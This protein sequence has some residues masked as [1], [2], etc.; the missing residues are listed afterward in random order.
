MSQSPPSVASA[1]G[2]AVAASGAG[3]A[4][5]LELT[6]PRI[7]LLVT[8][9]AAAGFALASSTPF[10]WPRFAA[11]LL[12][13]ALVA[14]GSA[15]FNMVVERKL[16]RNMRRTANRP[17]PAGRLAVAPAVAFGSILAVAGT[18]LLAWR[19]NPL[20]AA[21]GV[22]TFLAYVVVYTPMKVKSSLATLVGA[23]P[24][25]TPPVMG[26]AGASGEV[27]LGG[28]ILFSI[29]FLWQLPHF[30]AIAWMYREDYRR[31]GMPLLTVNDP[32]GRSTTRQAVL[33]A[34]ALLPVSLM[35]SAIG[36]TGW[37]HL[38]GALTF[39][40]VFLAAA[41]SFS[42]QPTHG[43]AKRLLLASVLYLPA[44]FAVAVVDHLLWR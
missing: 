12:G 27:G 14:A 38:A 28:W 1:A 44:V 18:L 24:G 20:T 5:W 29:L 25:A 19:V 13:T 8:L 10:D 34:V 4:D 11:T 9:T 16:D 35:P 43:H 2:A 15:T 32:D 7:T 36:I 40:I 37:P 6:K 42:R 21:I 26:W 23:I 39:G 30:L 3:V 31:A 41:W 33:Y 17:L 22:G